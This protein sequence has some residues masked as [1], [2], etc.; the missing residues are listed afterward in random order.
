MSPDPWLELQNVYWETDPPESREILA[1][2]DLRLGRDDRVG[3]LGHSGAGKTTL[4]LILA[5]LTRPTRGT[6]RVASEVGRLAVGLVFQEA[7]AS[8]FEETVVEDVAFGP[9]NFGLEDPLARAAEALRLVGL[10][11]DRIGRQ[12]PETLSGGEA[13]R[14]AIA[15]V[16]ACDPGLVVFDEPT[17]GLDAYGVAQFRQILERLRARGD[18]Y[19]LISHEIDLVAGECDRLV[20]LER[21]RIHW[22]GPAASLAAG[23]P[24]DW[25]RPGQELLRIRE[26]LRSRGW[27]SAELE[28]PVESLAEAIARRL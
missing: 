24:S 18:G 21:G 5:G 20:V 25:P 19:V 16:L 8:F 28:G 11:A 10:S 6:V 17:T 1:Q 22:Q 4:A 27:T 14:A 23:L 7:E 15:G 9:R 3:I 13:R 2:V 12:A 26:A